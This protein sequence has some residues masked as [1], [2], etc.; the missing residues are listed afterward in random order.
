[1]AKSG[2]GGGRGGRSRA[3][4][5]QPKM[6]SDGG[7]ISVNAETANDNANTMKAAARREKAA[8]SAPKS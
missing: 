7:P 8:K 3:E 2:G 6:K 1:M 5:E 4:A